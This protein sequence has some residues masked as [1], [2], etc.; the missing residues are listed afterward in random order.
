[1]QAAQAKNAQVMQ[2]KQFE[3]EQVQENQK[4]LGKAG[5]E[6]FRASIEKSTQPGMMGGPDQTQGFGATTAL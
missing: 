4:Q 1:M 2:Q 5:N 3:Q 6:A